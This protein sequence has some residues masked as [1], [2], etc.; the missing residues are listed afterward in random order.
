[1]KRFRALYV[2]FFLANSQEQSDQIPK[3]DEG[4]LRV[5]D[6]LLENFP[7]NISAENLDPRRH[8]TEGD[9]RETDE[10]A[11]VGSNPMTKNF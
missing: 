9:K 10:P 2:R 6:W 4:G 8:V 11:S 3:G 1:M 5:K 7:R